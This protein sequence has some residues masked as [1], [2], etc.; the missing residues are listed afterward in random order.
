MFSETMAAQ[1]SGTLP[2]LGSRLKRG[3]IQN[4]TPITSY[5]IQPKS[6][7]SMCAGSNRHSRGEIG[8]P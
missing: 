8:I 7:K 2:R 4:A 1:A 3:R 5:T 6:K